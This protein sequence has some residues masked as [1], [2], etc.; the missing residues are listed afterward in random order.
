[1]GRESER[2]RISV[3][4]R[5]VGLKVSGMALVSLHGLM[6]SDSKEHSLTMRDLGTGLCGGHRGK[7]TL[8]NGKAVST[9]AMAS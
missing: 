7:S 4:L 6:A 2:T 3:C 5:E 9:T 8:A 1:M